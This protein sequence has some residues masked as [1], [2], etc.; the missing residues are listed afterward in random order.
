VENWYPLIMD[1]ISRMS[2]LTAEFLQFSKPHAIYF[3][4]QPLQL[5]IQRVVS[6]MES[7]A[8]R[9]GH[10]IQ[11]DMP[12]ENVLILM[13][14]DK[15]VQ[16]L[17]N[18]VRNAFDAMDKNG[19]LEIALRQDE[20]HGYIRVKDHGKGIREEDLDKIFH[21][22]YTSKEEGTGLGLSICHKIVQDHGG[23]IEVKSKIHVG[24]E[25]MIT[26]PLAIAGN[27]PRLPSPEESG[28]NPRPGGLVSGGRGKA[29]LQRND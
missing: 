21:P 3:K 11:T 12:A 16:M 18:L 10:V 4:E 25:F 19:M 17:L 20:R 7:E 5:C 22:F 8:I 28:S 13:D 9:L 1:E 29:S 23:R 24:T 27:P 2:E 26:F 6:L 14:Q 15:I